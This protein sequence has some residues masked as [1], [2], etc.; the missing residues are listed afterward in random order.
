M[1]DLH[2]SRRPVRR[3]GA[4][5]C[6][7][8]GIWAPVVV[9]C[10]NLL[11]HAVRKPA[12]GAL[13][14]GSRKPMSCLGSDSGLLPRQMATPPPWLRTSR[15]ASALLLAC[16]QGCGGNDSPTGTEV[17]H[18]VLET[19]PSQT[20]R[21][22]IPL[23]NAP[24]LQLQTPSGEV[25]R[26]PG[27]VIN[28][29][30]AEGTGTL[31]GTV[32]RRTDVDGRVRFG[33]LS[34][35]GTIG[36]RILAFEGTNLSSV[37]SSPIVLSAGVP[38]VITVI[39][40][41]NQQAVAGTPL[42]IAPVVRL[43]DAAGNVVPNA[44]VHFTPDFNDAVALPV[45]TSD[46][47]GLAS[48]GTWV[49]GP[50]VGRR[51]LDARVGSVFVR[52]SATGTGFQATSISVGGAHSCA[53]N[54]VGEAYC[55]GENVFGQLGDGT[56]EDRLRPVLSAGGI[57]FRSVVA[58]QA[59][60]CGLT[61]AGDVLCWGKGG[62]LGDRSTADRAAPGRVP[63]SAPATTVTSRGSHTCVL[64]TD[65]TAWCWG[66]NRFGEIGD[67][68]L[69]PRMAP[70]PVVGL[71]RYTG[72]S[73]GVSHVCA[74]TSGEGG[75]CWGWNFHGVLGDGTTTD[76]IVPSPVPGSN[77]FA[78][79]VSGMATTCG[80]ASGGDVYC[81]GLNLQGQVGDGT[82]TNRLAPTRI[83]G[84]TRF[85]MLSAGMET[86]G[87]ATTGSAYCWGVWTW[88]PTQV[89]EMQTWSGVASGHNS[90]CGIE[91]S[92]QVFC[93]GSN[94]AG[95]IGDG[96]REHRTSPTPVLPAVVH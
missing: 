63:L 54:A 56:F 85:T 80:L 25:A 39:D 26:V 70:V 37:R 32:A 19:Q 75:W 28:V 58:S 87:V 86:C 48:A 74:A 9:F 96:T 57:K 79:L 41:D 90:S 43:N 69:L 16:V 52:F 67:G 68:T 83:F 4:R 18:L 27:R 60:T 95:Q 91:A 24:V 8:K 51:T 29:R 45:S 14:G 46:A 66:P 36:T 30:I 17:L 92:G 55:W 40:G 89:G 21:S 12:A 47:S 22:G 72:I 38:A 59:H 23:E 34:I 7:L 13:T 76:R 61:S 6:S 71:R 81:W 65:G 1:K 93:W 88:A 94:S 5:S 2:F 44:G 84:S 33:S 50:N 20:A 15:F 53:L 3:R 77:G 73:A 62:L 49:L 31:T 10:R 82:N 11:P 42:A 35:S 64:T 78:S